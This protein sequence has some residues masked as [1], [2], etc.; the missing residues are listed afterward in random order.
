VSDVEVAAELNPEIAGRYPH[1]NIASRLTKPH[2]R[3]LNGI[4]EAKTQK[5]EDGC[6]RYYRTS[7]K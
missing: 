2:D 7:E 4:G 6:E 5:F 1:F 3:R